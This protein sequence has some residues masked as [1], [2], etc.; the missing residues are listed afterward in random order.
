MAKDTGSALG[1]VMRPTPVAV[2]RIAAW[3]N[4]LADRGLALAPVSA[5]AM[6]P[7]DGPVKL[8]ERE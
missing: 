1:M 8:T 2:A 4:G 6:P 7:A 3:S 5:L